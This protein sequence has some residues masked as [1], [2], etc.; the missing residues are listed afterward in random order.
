MQLSVFVLSLCFTVN[1]KSTVEYMKLKVG[2]DNLL[3]P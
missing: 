3:Q 2:S 1:I